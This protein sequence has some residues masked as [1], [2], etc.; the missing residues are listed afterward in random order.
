[1]IGSIHTRA[2]E[3]EELVQSVSG[4]IAALDVAKRHI[5]ATVTALKRL[6]MLVSATEQ[7]TAFA[8]EKRFAQ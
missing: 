4:D 7:L 8:A 3:S 6:V 5:T 2:K 1:K